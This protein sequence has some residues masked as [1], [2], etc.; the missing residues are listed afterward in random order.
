MPIVRLNNAILYVRDVERSAAFYQGILDFEVAFTFPGAIFLR[1]SGSHNDH[2]L[3]LFAIGE[4]AG[5]SMAG[6]ATVGLYHLAWEVDTLNELERYAIRLAEAGAITGATDH[7][8]KKAVYAKDPDGIELSVTWI[9]PSY[10]VGKAELDARAIL[11]PLDIVKEKARY[12][13]TTRGGESV[14]F[15]VIPAGPALN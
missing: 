2:D 4:N 5:P 9:V 7:G 13:A 8:T 11:A 12:G 3:A 6:R 15:P 1:G 14:P 10:L